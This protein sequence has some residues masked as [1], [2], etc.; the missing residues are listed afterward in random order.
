[1]IDDESSVVPKTFGTRMITFSVPSTNEYFCSGTR[2]DYFAFDPSLAND[3]RTRPT[4][5]VF[6]IFE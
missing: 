3:G 4:Q 5:K 6:G 2:C 1:M